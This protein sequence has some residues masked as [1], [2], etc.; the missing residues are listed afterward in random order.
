MIRD[1]KLQK[2]RTILSEAG[3]GVVALSGG[4]DSV[5]LVWVASEIKALRLLAVT[6]NSPYMFGSEVSEAIK[7]CGSHGIDHKQ[8]IMGIP[9]AVKNNPPERCYL[10]KREVMSLIKGE[11]VKGEFRYVFDGTNS[12]DVSD[13]RPG[14][15]ALKEFGVRSPLLEAGLNKEEIRALSKEAGLPTWDKPSNACLMT[16]FPH[17]TAIS[18]DELRKAEAAEEI[19]SGLGMT[20]SRVRVHGDVVRIECRKEHMEALLE[21]KLRSNISEGLKALGYSYITV[22]LEGYRTGSMNRKIE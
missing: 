9:E 15:K 7:F 12:D 18:P 16:R 20:G 3:S 13:Y 22:D 10:C 14:M 1:E 2:L 11:A 17:G 4:T 21:E 6:V 19:L 8:L 5:F